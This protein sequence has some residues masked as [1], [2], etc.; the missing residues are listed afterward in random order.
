M[1]S[2]LLGILGLT[3]CAG[4]NA[5]S[6]GNAPRLPDFVTQ[7]MRNAPEDALV[8]IGTAKMA[9][10]AMSRKEAEARAK[11]EITRQMIIM[12]EDMV[13][14]YMAATEV[15]PSAGLS[16]AEDMTAEDMTMA[17]SKVDLSGVVVVAENIDNDGNYWVV[18]QL[19][20][21]A[22]A[23]EIQKAQAAAK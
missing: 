23:Q 8:G 3:A 14:D 22:T 6:G 16:F 10:L 9:T 4:V 11:E 18:V 17:I 2:N 5:Q 20:R 1:K 15:D 19:S 13:R 12:V 21:T 7:A